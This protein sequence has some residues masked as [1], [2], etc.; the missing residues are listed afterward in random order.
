SYQELTRAYLGLPQASGTPSKLEE[1]YR[2]SEATLAKIAQT[3]PASVIQADIDTELAKDQR[4]A[5]CDDWVQNSP[6]RA[7]CISNKSTP[8]GAGERD[9]A[10]ASRERASVDV[11]RIELAHHRK[12]S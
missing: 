7:T 10:R 9:C 6:L 12:A 11:S 4:L 1:A 2:R 8:Q 5:A 3:R